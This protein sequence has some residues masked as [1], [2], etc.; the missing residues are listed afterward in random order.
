VS[1]SVQG[2]S[3]VFTSAGYGSPATV[4]VNVTSGSRS[5]PLP[6]VLS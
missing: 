6:A 2:N 5:S 1:A 4:A 3:I